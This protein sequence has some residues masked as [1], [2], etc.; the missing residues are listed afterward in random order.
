VVDPS[1]LRQANDHGVTICFADLDG[2]DGLWVPEER[3]VLVSRSLSDEKI[4]EVIE[5][6]LAHVKIDD[7]HADLDA[8]REVLVGHPPARSRRYGA[9]VLTAAG[10]LAV[11][12]GVTYGVARATGDPQKQE[13]VVAPV[14]PGLTASESAPP[15][16]P[17][18]TVIASVGP[19]GQVV[20]K[21]LVITQ[22]PPFPSSSASSAGVA[23]SSPAGRAASPPLAPKT[24]VAVPPPA[25]PT[26]GADPTTPAG[27]D[28][29][30]PD[31]PSDTPPPTTPATETTPAEAGASASAAGKE[32]GADAASGAADASDV[33]VAVGGSGDPVVAP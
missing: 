16:P 28:P 22:T 18:T 10:L 15:A 17:G 11:V 23:T 30:L 14:P 9:A 13:Q 19:D 2:A 6:E 21:T 7:Q 33:T 4:A 26:G 32:T 12:G 31:P 29:T 25:Q 27:P 3:T 1:L 24:T 20:Y 5:H 8:G